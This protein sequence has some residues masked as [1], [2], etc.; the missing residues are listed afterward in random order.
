MEN[1]QETITI[2]RKLYD[3]LDKDQ[4]MLTCLMEAGVDNWPG[5]AIALESY[6]EFENIEDSE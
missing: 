5:Y 4:L 2:S 3:Q 6:R 1:N